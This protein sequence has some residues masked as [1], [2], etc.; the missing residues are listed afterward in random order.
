[1]TWFQFTISAAAPGMASVGSQLI[2]VDPVAG[3]YTSNLKQ[4]SIYTIYITGEGDVTPTLATGAT[5]APGT[6]AAN[7]PQPRLPLS[8]TVGGVQATVNFAGIPPGLAG[9][10]QINFT[11]PA[12]AP[13]GQQPVVVTVGS[14]ASPPATVTVTQ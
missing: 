6:P 7:L 8:V 13:L 2:V 14:A 1:V 3:G 9:V 12:A 5:P 4:G 11:V 10:T